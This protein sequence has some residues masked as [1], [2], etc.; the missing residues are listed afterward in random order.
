MKMEIQLVDSSVEVLR[1]P[2]PGLKPGRLDIGSD[3]ISR[4]VDGIQCSISHVATAVIKGLNARG[5]PLV[6]FRTN[7]C[8]EPL[9]ALTILPIREKDISREA[10]IIFDDGDLMRPIILGLLHSQ[11]KSEGEVNIV[12]D[13]E[14][15]VLTGTRE[16]VLRCG[17]ASMTLTRAGK[18][19]IQGEYVL[20]R[21]KGVN[22]IK[23]AS[24]QIN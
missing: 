12:L 21:S 10:V 22:R 24:V 1:T 6:D 18:V 4:E 19:L 14:S 20:T 9:R 2:Q 13:G 16:I 11:Q 5:E 7:P 8:G 3:P 15:L 17:G 23:G